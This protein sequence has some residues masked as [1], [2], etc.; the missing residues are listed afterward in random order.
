MAKI[1]PK[2][3]PEFD[4]PCYAVHWK[5]R[6]SVETDYTASSVR[7]LAEIMGRGKG[8]CTCICENAVYNGRGR[9]LYSIFKNEEE[10]TDFMKSGK[11]YNMAVKHLPTGNVW[12]N[13]KTAAKWLGVPY[14]TM[15]F[16]AKGGT[17]F[18][19]VQEHPVIKD[20]A[21]KYIR[22]PNQPP[23]FTWTGVSEA[24]QLKNFYK[25]SGD[26]F[27]RVAVN[28]MAKLK[29]EPY[30][31]VG[32]FA[33]EP[34]KIISMDADGSAH[35]YKVRFKNGDIGYLSHDEFERV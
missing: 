3:N 8:A 32:H 6:D 17:D 5:S 21:L 26:G 34:V 11:Q 9:S 23:I 33:G 15:N 31:I 29:K 4:R 1:M 10:F 20:P 19:R 12:E 13:V 14:P 27:E 2:R 35:P 24:D 28:S 30:L 18:K 22:K 25:H 16:Y 7:E